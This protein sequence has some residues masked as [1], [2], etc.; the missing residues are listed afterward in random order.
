MK[1]DRNWM[2]ILIF[3][4]PEV[5]KF[6]FPECLIQAHLCKKFG[7]KSLKSSLKFNEWPH[8]F[9]ISIFVFKKQNKM[10]H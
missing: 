4:P 6:N 10:F 9:N 3:A 2:R 8:F 5:C 7:L 1:P